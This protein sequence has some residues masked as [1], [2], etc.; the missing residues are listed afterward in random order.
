MEATTVRWSWAVGVE[1]NN[2]ITPAIKE[3]VL[4][5]C[6]GSITADEFI[7]NMKAAAGK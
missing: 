4:K 2:D 3:N 1:S 7:A 5:L 6:G